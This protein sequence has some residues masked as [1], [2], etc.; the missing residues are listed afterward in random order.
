MEKKKKYLAAVCTI[1]EGVCSERGAAE[2][3]EFVMAFHYKANRLMEV[4]GVTDCAYLARLLHFANRDRS[5]SFLL[6]MCLEVGRIGEGDRSKPRAT[7][8]FWLIMHL[9]QDAAAMELPRL[10]DS[11]PSHTLLAEVIST[12][13]PSDIRL[14]EKIIRYVIAKA[15][16]DA[17]YMERIDL[18][19]E[20]FRIL[21]I[22]SDPH[23]E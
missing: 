17:L 16:P 23:L 14:Q 5:H 19:A 3:A 11:P 15:Y 9:H 4:T 6:Q 7:L 18:R 13:C 2:I 21:G 20:S 12:L 22:E 10:A 1:V 8:A